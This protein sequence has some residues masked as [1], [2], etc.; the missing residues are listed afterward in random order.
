MMSDVSVADPAPAQD[1]P[2]PHAA[3]GGVGRMI[4]SVVNNPVAAILLTVLLLGGG[5]FI[6]TGIDRQLLPNVD[7]KQIVITVPY[8]GANLDEVDENVTRRIEGQ[9]QG[10]AGTERVTARSVAGRATLIVEVASLAQ[11]DEVLDDVRAAIDRLEAFP[12]RDA[13]RPHVVAGTLSVPA[14]SLAVTSESLD[15]DG[16]RLAAERLREDLLTLAN[17]ASVDIEWA[18]E[19]QVTVEL[20]E[21]ALREHDLTIAGVASRLR[22]ASADL[23]AGELATDA[24]GLVLRVDERRHR[25]EDYEDIVLL[26]RPGGA[27]VRL[28]DVAI[29][30]DAFADARPVS[31]LDGVPAL[32]VSARAGRGVSEIDLASEIRKLLADYEPT[33]GTAVAMWDD[34]SMD[35]SARVNAMV[36]TGLL[37]LALVFVVLALT[38]DF[39]LAFWITAGIPTAFLGAMLLFPALGLTINLATMFALIVAIGIVVG[40]AVV[41]GESVAREQEGGLTGAEAAIEGAGK[42][43]WPLLVAVGTT[44][45][46]V[47]PLLFLDGL[48]GQFLNVAPA[49]LLVLAVSLLHAFLILPSHLAHGRGWSRWP[50]SAVQRR[51]R[52]GIDDFRDGKAVPAIGAAIRHPFRSLL[53]ALAVVAV[54]GLVVATDVVRLVDFGELEVNTIEA[55]VTFPAGTPPART[56]VG[57]RQLVAAAEQTNRELPGEPIEAIAMVVGHGFAPLMEFQADQAAYRSNVAAVRLRLKAESA[58]SVS[59]AAV[60]SHWQRRVGEVIGAQRL[61]FG[62]RLTS[63][64]D[65]RVALSHPDADTLRAAVQ[66]LRA[67]VAEVPGTHALADSLTGGKRH[68]DLSVSDVGEVAGLTPRRLAAGLR[69]R[70]HGAEVQRIQR[71]RDEIKVMVRYP[72][73]RR[74]SFAEL[75]NE[76]IDLPGGGAIPLG[77]AVNI[78][79]TEEFAAVM[80]ID[81]IRAAEVSGHVDS[82]VTS[83]T[84]LVS[85]LEEVALPEIIARYPGLTSAATGPAADAAEDF[86]S[87]GFTVPLAL[88]AM[89]MLLAVLFRSY[90]QP[91]IVLTAMPL[92]AS[93]AVLAH[94]L[95][96]Y[97]MNLASLLGL[98]AVLGLAINDTVLLMDRYSAIRAQGDIPAVAAVSGA[99]R[100]RFRP[101]L[102]TTVTT[103]VALLPVLYIGSEAMQGTLVPFAVSV[104][105]G[106]IAS[107]AAI[108][109]LVPAV[110]LVAE[111]VDERRDELAA[112]AAA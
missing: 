83:S 110:M 73:E 103:V 51:F 79:E 37:S 48:V 85:H 50:M 80:R 111:R 61:A 7:L 21:E 109:F 102:M 100:Q 92:A 5:A 14:V 112:G 11:T 87:L 60:E 78:D 56:E 108:L 28:G 86:A 64:S 46:G 44:M 35:L 58:R 3:G 76:R 105:G 36:N 99:V 26:A 15:A 98:V 39:R 62:T 19:R 10:I 9:V 104:L 96:G 4:A 12:P 16:L 69:N 68:F 13:E 77:L 95:L 107:C 101:I 81:G 6:A 57:A 34:G 45:F 38:L 20:S 24:G 18:A 8:P 89:Y 88:L 71:G 70:F 32:F 27:I 93:G 59:A 17:V 31:E 2:E 42:V 54:A 67:A 29:V 55:D 1:T 74:A 90:G 53:V 91:L 65:F 94:L 22:R 97:G 66:D 63:S 40:D 75:A 30:R 106:L 47:L 72:T 49:L 41:V 82:N 52:T 33:P 84:T 43:F 23:T 25:G